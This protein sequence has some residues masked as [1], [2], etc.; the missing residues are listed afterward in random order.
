[1]IAIFA[2]FAKYRDSDGVLN[3]LVLDFKCTLLLNC[4]CTDENIS[5]LGKMYI[6]D[7]QFEKIIDGTVMKLLNLHRKQ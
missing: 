2:Y 6:A 5:G 3:V 4:T 1:M 7:E